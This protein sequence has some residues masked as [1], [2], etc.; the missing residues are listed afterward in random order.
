MKQTHEHM[1]IPAQPGLKR[2]TLTV[3]VHGNV[4]TRG[5]MRGNNF[6]SRGQISFGKS[7]DGHRHGRLIMYVWHGASR[8]IYK[9]L[10]R[11]GVDCK[12]WWIHKTLKRS[13]CVPAS[14]VSKSREP[15]E[16]NPK[17][18]WVQSTN[19]TGNDKNKGIS[20]DMGF[21]IMLH[22]IS[23]YGPKEHFCAFLALS[24]ENC[25]RR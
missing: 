25:R 11:C 12:K 21:Q 10:L 3:C 17:L 16:N 15:G 7:A 2:T 19:S 1:K 14:R 8:R 20:R 22:E 5:H 6:S 9:D 4:L 24:Y 13:N 23:A 18:L